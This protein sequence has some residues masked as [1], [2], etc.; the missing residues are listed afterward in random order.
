[1]GLRDRSPSS[2]RLCVIPT[3]GARLGSRKRRVAGPKANDKTTTPPSRRDHGQPL[4][5]TAPREL[6]SRG[7]T[8]ASA[9]GSCAARY[10][11]FNTGFLLICTLCQA[12]RE[13]RGGGEMCSP[14]KC[15]WVVGKNGEHAGRE[16]R[17][18]GM[19]RCKT[20]QIGCW[21]GLERSQ[22]QLHGWQGD[23]CVLDS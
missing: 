3:R 7:R 6:S 19:S 16:K 14:S 21:S 13:G 15:S 20:G 11:Y 9:S 2:H 17:L 4:A 22:G 12:R 18:C 23:G 8:P 5:K 10:A 1:M